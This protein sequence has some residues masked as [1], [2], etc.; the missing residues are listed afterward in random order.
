M[1]ANSCDYGR[2][3]LTEDQISPS[4]GRG[5]DFLGDHQLYLSDRAGPA[6][7]NLRHSKADDLIGFDCELNKGCEHDAPP[8]RGAMPPLATM[9]PHVGKFP[10]END[11]F[12]GRT[13]KQ[14]KRRAE[15]RR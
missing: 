4:F 7:N 9:S 3:T 10:K 8:G 12:G 15:H 13:V 11:S 5:V 6:R 2:R 14:D 1:L